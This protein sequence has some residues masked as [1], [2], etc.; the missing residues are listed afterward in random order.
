MAGIYLKGQGSCW[1]I[2]REQGISLKSIWCEKFKGT[3][4]QS[5]RGYSGFQVM[6]IKSNLKIYGSALAAQ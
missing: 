4:P 2:L 6:G 1:I 3:I 5:Q